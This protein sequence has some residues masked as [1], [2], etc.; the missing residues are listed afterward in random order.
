METSCNKS[1]QT[2]ESHTDNVFLF[3]CVL[4]V[5][6]YFS[7]NKEMTI[8]KFPRTLWICIIIVFS[9]TFTKRGNS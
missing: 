1:I 8:R 3:L 4:F 5:Y 6:K 9:I 7:G 2:A